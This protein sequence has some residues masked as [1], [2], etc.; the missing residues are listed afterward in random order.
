MLAV[1][2]I[3]FT[4]FFNI[5]Q[6]WWDLTNKVG[7]YVAVH[8]SERHDNTC[9]LA[10]CALCMHGMETHD[11][12]L[13]FM[14]HQLHQHGRQRFASRHSAPCCHTHEL[15]CFHKLPSA[16]IV[17]QIMC[18]YAYPQLAMCLNFFTIIALCCYQ[19]DSHVCSWR[20]DVFTR[21]ECCAASPGAIIITTTG[22]VIHTYHPQLLCHWV[23]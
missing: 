9:S 15:R 11:T 8:C 6:P 13:P 4:E 5:A 21:N 18:G 17:L 10:Y 12:H 14:L 23:L 2:G 19:P 7:H 16:E 1:A 20:H 3:L 22:V